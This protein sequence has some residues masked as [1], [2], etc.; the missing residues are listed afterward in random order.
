MGVI[1]SIEVSDSRG[2]KEIVVNT[3]DQGNGFVEN[4]VQENIPSVDGTL[5]TPL[6]PSDKHLESNLTNQAPLRLT[7]GGDTS[8]EYHENVSNECQ[9]NSPSISTPVRLPECEGASPKCVSNDNSSPVGG[10]RMNVMP[11]E[12]E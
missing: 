6:I 8:F 5:S 4:I 2:D 7:G 12:K 3:N 11:W 10:I 1:N 9:D